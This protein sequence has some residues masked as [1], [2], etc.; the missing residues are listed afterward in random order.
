[1]DSSETDDT[2]KHGVINF[3]ENQIVPFSQ[4]ID[5][6]I[7]ES[8]II[9]YKQ[10][11]HWGAYT[12]QGRVICEPLYDYIVYV[13][14]KLI[15]VGMNDTDYYESNEDFFWR[16]DKRYDFTKYNEYSIINWGLIDNFGNKLLPLKY[17]A[18]ADKIVDGLLEIRSNSKIGYVD[19]TGHL[20][21]EPT[22]KSVSD[23][24]DG[25]AIVSKTFLYYDYEL[26]RDCKQSK[27]GVI[28]SC[29]TELIPCVFGSIEYET[30]TGLFK[31][32][33][34]YKTP[35]GRYIAENDGEEIYV[36]NKYKYC[37]P[38]N[39]SCAIA[40]SVYDKHVK[41]GLI[42]KKSNDILPPIFSYLK[43]LDNGLY[44]FKINDLY[45]LVNSN[46]NIV[47]PNRYN[48]I[49][50]FEDDLACVQI[51][52]LTDNSYDK[53]ELYGYVD[54]LGNEVLS[55]SYDFIGKRNNKYSVVMKNNL[56]GLFGIENHQIKKIPNVAYLGP[57]MENLCKINIGGNYNKNNKKITGGRWGYVSVNG[58][59]VIEPSYEQAYSFSDGMAAVNINGKWGFINV[60][61]VIVVPCEYDKVESSF[62]EGKGKLIR[63]RN[64]YVFDKNGKLVDSYGNND[65]IDD[66]QYYGYDFDT[67]TYNKY[68]G[69]NGYSDQAID[70]AFEGDPSLTWNCD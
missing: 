56:W 50:K 32:N 64:V 40:V 60:D 44:K 67:P 58:Q 30:E 35:D 59:I 23:F 5:D 17:R 24:V 46:G 28:N 53:K 11:W 34:G 10:D 12:L 63:D 21:L 52:V 4:Q 38:F 37:K 47:L 25:Y 9:L 62:K 39:D 61:G 66:E 18:I 26:G 14:D 22:Y 65:C 2:S 3:Q 48:G 6:I 31:T 68:G 19:I 33:V 16:D 13:S 20:L 55:P 43:L 7:I 45:G 69:Y 51:N 15:K 42:D 49:G 54:S 1:M 70:E 57:C 27:Y 36:D 41:Y 29:F 8:D